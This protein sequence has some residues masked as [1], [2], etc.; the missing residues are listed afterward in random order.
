[1]KLYT[2]RRTQRLPISV[3]EAWEFFSDPANLKTI[4][5]PYMGF[6]IVSGADRKMYPGQV[7][8]YIVTPL[9]GIKMRWVTEITHV[10]DGKYFVDEQRFGPYALW[11][12]KHFFRA[13]D[14]GTEMEDIVDYGLPLGFLGRWMHPIIVKGKLEEI[15]D[16]RRR[17]MLELFGPYTESKTV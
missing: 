8:Q 16:F 10:E 4:T 6:N 2:L 17:R 5:P 7:I 14:G 11:H 3:S 9:F 12:H 13:V 1:M 15:F